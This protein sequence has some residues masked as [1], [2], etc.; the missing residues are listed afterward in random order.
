VGFHKFIPVVARA[1]ESLGGCSS[2]LGRNAKAV[3]FDSIST[4]AVDK[5]R[6]KIVSPKFQMKLVLF[7]V[8]LCLLFGQGACRRK[9]TT[10]GNAN[11]LSG[12]SS[13]A[14]GDRTQA[15]VLLEQG[16]EAYRTDQDEKAADAFEQAVKLDPNLAEAEFRLALAYEALGKT[17]EVEETYKKAIEK[18]KKYLESNKD[19]A[20]GHYNLGQTYAGLHL[21]TE[22]VREYRQAIHLK[23]DDADVYYDL[24]TALTK[25]AQYDEAAAAFS[26]SLEID[27]ENYRA[28]DALEEAREGVQ[29]IKA[30]KKHQEDLLKKQKEGELKNANGDSPAGT[31][32]N[33]SPAA[34][35]NSNRGNKANSNRASVDKSNSNRSKKPGE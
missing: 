19:D 17:Q 33:N 27:P 9:K 22:A 1:S 20:E 4:F 24:G 25:L 10:G 32:S 8:I 28:Q 18:Y 35:S 2:A 14:E 21:Y 26:K 29:R 3:L 23:D 31:T 30:G 15:R 5:E 34:K 13:T 11:S 7:I 16:K 12:V 6:L